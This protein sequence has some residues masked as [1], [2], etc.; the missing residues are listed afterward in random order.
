MKR[1]T[2]ALVVLVAVA[3]GA[4]IAVGAQSPAKAK[5]SPS[6]E[7]RKTKLGRIVVDAHGR[8]LYLFEADRHGRSTCY[9]ACAGGWP[10]AL[11][12][13]KPVAGQ[14]VSASKLGTTRRHNGARQ[15]TLGG[16]PLYRFVVDKK[17]GDTKG[18]DLKAFGADWYA[19]RGSGRK[20]PG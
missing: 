8:T 13:G 6:V 18:Q 1:V 11:V 2:L 19:V 5:R 15:L 9:G 3:G 10:P 20:V 7:L 4:A 17:P 12:K 14:G 16:H